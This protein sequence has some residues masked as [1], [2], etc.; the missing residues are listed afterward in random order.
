MVDRFRQLRRTRRSPPEPDIRTEAIAAARA[1]LNALADRSRRGLEH[2]YAR[3]CVTRS[4]QAGPK[5]WSTLSRSPLSA[6]ARIGLDWNIAFEDAYRI[7]GAPRRNLG[8]TRT[9]GWAGWSTGPQPTSAECSRRAAEDG[10]T[11]DAMVDAAMDVLTSED[12]PE[13]VAFVVDWAMTTAADDG[14]LA[15]TGPKA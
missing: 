3:P 2:A 11:R 10:A 9:A 15:C 8:A 6:P 5:A 4:P 7:A 12:D 14:A 13:A 1:M